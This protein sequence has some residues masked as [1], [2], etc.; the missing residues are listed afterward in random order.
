MDRRRLI[1]AAMWALAPG[2]GWAAPP[3][4]DGWIDPPLPLDLRLPALVAHKLLMLTAAR[5]VDVTIADPVPAALGLAA[6][7]Y[8]WAARQM[9]VQ[10]AG[11]FHHV[12]ISQGRADDSPSDMV[13]SVDV[14]LDT[15]YF[16]VGNDGSLRA[17]TT[18]GGWSATGHL[19]PSSAKASFGREVVFWSAYI[20]RPEGQF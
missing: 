12:A 15:W 5:G 9:A 2:D 10:Q 6:P 16:S 18:F 3:Q 1:V 11:A 17:S 4:G 8:P 19:S 20:E 7:G 13:L 14:S